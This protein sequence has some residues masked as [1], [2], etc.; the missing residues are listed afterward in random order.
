[1]LEI[2]LNPFI[3]RALIAIILI[4]VISA[5]IGN[6]IFYR[7]ESFLLVG[8]AH[9]AMAGA[10]LVMVLSSYLLL[11]INPLVGA[12]IFSVLIVIPYLIEREKKTFEELESFLGLI[13]AFTLAAAV[14]FISLLREYATQA[15][16]LIIGDILLLT[17]SDVILLMILSALS[18]LVVLTFIRELL[19]ISFDVESS[20]II[21][22]K[23]KIFEYLFG[24]ALAAGVVVLLK[25]VG[26][27]LIYIFAIAPASVANR[28]SN[29]AYRAMFLTFIIS[30]T[31]GILSILIG[32]LFNIP[33]STLAG[34]ILALMYIAI[35]LVRRK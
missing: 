24:I 28:I 14:F 1:M 2:F 19:Y 31:V 17:T 26:A 4:S 25:S 10:A 23:S 30:V 15:W 12:L 11:R 13:F 18:V 3:F 34:L 33:P 16:G 35:E 5:T 7:G 9:A 20:L 29:D 6:L 22:P 8:S 27:L 32:V 21:Y